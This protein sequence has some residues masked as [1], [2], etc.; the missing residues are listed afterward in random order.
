MER[1]IAAVE[2]IND[3]GAIG[4][5]VD[6]DDG[7]RRVILTRKGDRVSVFLNSCPHTGVRLDWK[8]GQFLDFDDVLLQCATHG[9]LFSLDSGYCV[10]GPC[11]GQNLVRLAVDVRD[12]A[13]FIDTTTPV[14][15][16]A[17]GHVVR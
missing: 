8:P 10:A 1:R 13:I 2:D 16:T 15:R 11:S 3:G 9:A 12:G 7:P 17:L 4:A 14:P 5:V 6:I